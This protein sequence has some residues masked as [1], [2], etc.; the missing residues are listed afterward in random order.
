MQTH[1]I[2]HHLGRRVEVLAS[3]AYFWRGTLRICDFLNSLPSLCI[4]LY[5]LVCRNMVQ[6]WD[7]NRRSIFG[8]HW[9]NLLRGFLAEILRGCVRL[10]LAAAW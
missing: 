10:R 1:K 7:L 5:C 6:G 8:G 4:A 9:G 3:H 2:F